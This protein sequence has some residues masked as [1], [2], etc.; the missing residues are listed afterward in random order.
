MELK[1][2]FKEYLT[3]HK[4]SKGRNL[5]DESVRTY[6][7][8]VNPVIDK[9]QS[10]LEDDEIENII[11]LLKRDLKNDGN[12]VKLSSYKHLLRFL[13]VDEDLL[14]GVLSSD[15]VPN[16][17]T[18]ENV[19]DKVLR[20]EEVRKL[21]V[22]TKDLYFKFLISLLYDTAIRQGTARKLRFKHLTVVDK[23]Y[24]SEERVKE[25]KS[26]GVWG[27]LRVDRKGG[28]KGT[29]YITENTL[30][31]LNKLLKSG[32]YDQ[33]K[34]SERGISEAPIVRFFKDDGEL[35]KNQQSTFTKLFSKH[36]EN[37]LGVEGITP[38]CMR[39]TALTH[40]M[41]NE[42]MSITDVQHYAGHSNVE[43]TMIYILLGESYSKRAYSKHKS[44]TDL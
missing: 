34:D 29:V 11:V 9:V 44:V 43:T 40:M 15:L 13:G 27:V 3:N 6:L 28:K 25:Y 41:D 22:E 42:N 23:E 26:I 2:R 32:R 21:Y 20:H 8:G 33:Y 10:Y 35:Y 30:I 7:A 37:V 12:G 39:H 17:F 1:K 31:L 5:R 24:M 14:D 4:T 18:V 16:T 38:H 36:V 19:K